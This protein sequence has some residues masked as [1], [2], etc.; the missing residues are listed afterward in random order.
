MLGWNPGTEQEIFSLSELIE[1]F[2]LERVNKSGARFDP[3]KTKWYNQ[4]YLQGRS[5]AALAESYAL[6]L[7]EKLPGAD[8]PAFQNP[9]TSSPV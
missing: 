2:S 8:F 6:V 5:D 4:Q 3:D 9:A 7:D 1:A